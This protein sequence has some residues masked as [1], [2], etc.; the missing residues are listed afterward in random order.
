MVRRLGVA[1]GLSDRAVGALW[2]DRRGFLWI[3]TAR[4]LD[5]FDG[6]EIRSFAAVTGC[7]LPA[8]AITAGCEDAA[9][10]VWLGTR[11]GLFCYDPARR[12][13]RA[14]PLGPAQGQTV[15]AITIT[16]DQH[17]WLVTGGYLLEVV[18]GRVAHSWLVRT[19][20]HPAPF[21]LTS[22]QYLPAERAFLLE[23]FEGP[24]LR[25]VPAQGRVTQVLPTS[26]A[27]LVI[28]AQTK[29]ER[30]PLLA[31]AAAL[32]TAA[33]TDTVLQPLAIL[34]RPAWPDD[35][36][37]PRLKMA[38][39]TDAAGRLWLGAGRGQLTRYD[40]RTRTLENLS[41]LLA[42]N[43]QVNTLLEDRQHNLW[44]GTEFGL[45]QLDN[46]PRLFERL[47]PPENLWTRGHTF[48]TRGLTHDAEGNLYV[49]SYAGLF[50]QRASTGEWERLSLR[51]QGRIINF[52]PYALAY[53]GRDT[54]WIGCEGFGLMSYSL[55]H[56]SFA[57]LEP[58][59]DTLQTSHLTYL[60][61]LA[62]DTRGRLWL[63][64]YRDLRRYDPR[65]RR[66]ESLPGASADAVR[67]NALLPTPDGGMVA[68]TA[69]GVF[70]LTPDGHVHE[71]WL[72]PADADLQ[73]LSEVLAAWADPMGQLWLGTRAGLVHLDPHTGK[74]HTWRRTDGLADEQVYTLL[75]EGDSAV[76]LGTQRGLSRLSLRAGARPRNFFTVDGLANDEFNHGSAGYLP[77]GRLVMGGLS[78]LSVVAPD[79][80][81]RATPPADAPLLISGLTFFNGTTGHLEE[82]SEPSGSQPLVLAPADRLLAVR[83]AL[84][85]FDDP[86]LHRYEYRLDGFDSR[87]LALGT[88]RVLRLATLPAGSYTLR[89]RASGADGHW[90]HHQLVLPLEVQPVFWRTPWFA[91]LAVLALVAGLYGLH[92]LRLRTVVREERLRA[93]M[94]ARDR[95]YALVGHDLRGPVNTFN[96]AVRLLEHY[97]SQGQTDRLPALTARVRQSAGQLNS[98]LNNLLAWAGAQSGDLPFAP[99]ELPLR[100]LLLENRDLFTPE[101]E[102]RQV[103]LTVEVVEG[104]T[105]RAD[106]QMMRTVL[107][108]LTANALRAVA[109]GGWVR[110]AATPADDGIWLEV[111]DNGPGLPPAHAATLTSRSA[112][113]TVA[114]A[115]VHGTGLGLRLVRLFVVRH[116]GRIEVLVPPGG[117]TAVRIWLPA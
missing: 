57:L 99:T 105:V 108:N 74:Y 112:E 14:V 59:L 71:A 69:R 77:D 60:T 101:A 16:P 48:S 38:A 85:D 4:G 15:P 63:G 82:R 50:R 111:T 70:R 98:L 53:D 61:C 43:Y 116:R 113:P 107:R 6:Y 1:D 8:G 55:K 90:S 91:A 46:R 13:L 18:A 104:L 88:E 3:G 52:T 56:D 87:W 106:G 84:A 32:F 114:C 67:Y 19:A 20:R 39:L 25:F 96:G 100:A 26:A 54:L 34:R 41:A 28:V 97:L 9:G 78:G 11:Q 45:V 33:P 10:R 58:H 40:P 24:A 80:G 83:F 17:V 68:A 81:T 89:V 117:G 35:P 31:T 73:P 76:W 37:H 51:R 64:G 109:D 36:Y 86:A 110:L 102:I 29:A 93:D 72:Q 12:Q 2:Q 49:A 22:L 44:L 75:A 103:T 23:T 94:A 5:R 66:F 115:P 7:R 79:A 47:A 62:T 21:P 30:R 92:R 42:P 27:R 95:L 65:S